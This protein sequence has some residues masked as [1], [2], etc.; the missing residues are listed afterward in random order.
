M[1]DKLHN[2]QIEYVTANHT[3]GGMYNWNEFCMHS[4]NEIWGSNDVSKIPEKLLEMIKYSEE[5]MNDR[6]RVELLNLYQSYYNAVNMINW[7]CLSYASLVTKINGEDVQFAPAEDKLKK[8]YPILSIQEFKE[9]LS[10]VKK[11]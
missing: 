9:N 10:S 2:V 8:I 5:G 3:K 11:K 6:L 4:T 7:E 1:G